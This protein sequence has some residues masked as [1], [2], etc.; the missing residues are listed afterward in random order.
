MVDPFE[1]KG[2]SRRKSSEIVKLLHRNPSY[3]IL[4]EVQSSDHFRAL[5]HAMAA[6]IRVMHT[7]HASGAVDFVRRV[8][9]VYKIPVDL[10]CNLDLI[11]FLRKEE[12][13]Q[14]TYRS[15]ESVTAVCHADGSEFP[16]LVSVRDDCLDPSS[17]EKDF[18]VL[19][20]EV[21][22]KR[23]L[24]QGCVARSYREIRQILAQLSSEGIRDLET[25]R[26]RVSGAPPSLPTGN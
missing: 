18:G 2:A 12:H 25:V 11:V 5:F 3:V 15:V 21:E 20:D 1:S 13:E 24:G 6:G 22:E 4:G 7:S 9:R 19:I 14:G 16:R 23:E 26:G 17:R 8:N 10:I